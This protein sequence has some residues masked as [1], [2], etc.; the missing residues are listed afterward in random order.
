MLKYQ[1][2]VKINNIFICLIFTSNIIHLIRAKGK[3]I[4]INVNLDTLM[5]L[6]IK[7]L[8]NTYYFLNS[9]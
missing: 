4:F 7:L 6:K 3:I 1:Y 9:Q 2:L 5:H 8:T